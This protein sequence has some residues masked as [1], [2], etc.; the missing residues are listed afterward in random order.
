MSQVNRDVFGGKRWELPP[1]ILHPFSDQTG[2]DKLLESSRASLILNGVLPS[3]EG[4]RDELTRRLLEGRFCEIRMLY[5]V[6]K[7]LFRWIEQ[8]V[9]F[10]DSTP[11]LQQLGIRGESFADLL[12]KNPPSHVEDKLKSWG[13]VDYRAIFARAMG[14]NSIFAEA[15]EAGSLTLDFVRHYY[16]FADHLFTCRQAIQPFTQ[17]TA[18]TFDFEIY[19]SGEYSRKLEESWRV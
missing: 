4:D 16:R 3:D 19:A 6:G 18:E 15:P 14:L 12:V 9:E 2:P 13:V 17:I 11:E 1:L 8:C 10:V 5:F 7:D